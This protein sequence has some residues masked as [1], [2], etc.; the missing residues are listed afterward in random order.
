M[1]TPSAEKLEEMII[2]LKE[3]LE[4]CDEDTIKDELITEIKYR[5][6]QLR[7]L[8]IQNEAL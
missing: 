8:T 4:F 5:E 7:N 2:D 3:Q 1:E 6:N